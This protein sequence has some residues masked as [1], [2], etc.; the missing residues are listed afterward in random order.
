M[1]KYTLIKEIGDGAYGKVWRAVN[2]QSGEAVA[3]KVL[4]DGC[5]SLEE[6]LNLRE[7]K[8]LR[9]L[10][11]HS[12]IVKLK[13]LV[14]QNNVLYFV[15]EY[16]DCDLH[17]LM[18]D[19]KH[20][21]SEAEVRNFCFQLFQ[22]LNYMHQQGYLHRDLKPDNL[23][24][25]KEIIKIAD[26]GLA[27]EIETSSPYT[28]DITT[29]S[30]RAPEMFF[31]CQ[32]SSKVDM[33]AMGVIMAEMITLRLLFPGN[34]EA[35]QIYDICNAIGSPTMDTWPEGLALANSINFKFPNFSSDNLS[36]LI[37]SANDDEINLISSLLSWD[38][39]KRP[40]AA[41][42]LQHPYFLSCFHVPPPFLSGSAPRV[43]GT[44]EN[45]TSVTIA[46][47]RQSVVWWKPSGFL[48]SKLIHYLE[49]I[50]IVSLLLLAV[51]SACGFLF[52]S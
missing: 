23:L 37:P 42:A 33:W 8:C 3:I 46:C 29:L 52:V 34:G 31:P 11:N 48:Y 51:F 21:F 26:F 47:G 10:N 28:E 39:S 41:E 22:G 50:F 16:M 14:N 44:A 25:S 19:R 36:A 7:V 17:Q 24:V 18:H 6:C 27:R 49:L 40:T 20:F 5:T 35:D 38:P 2:K 32:Y 9:K 4:K 45:L 15:F 12:N 1:E 30:Y 13:E 43:A